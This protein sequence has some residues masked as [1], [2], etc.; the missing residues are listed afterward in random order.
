[1]T[2]VIGNT[3]HIKGK[4]LSGTPE[5]GQ[6]W[7]FDGSGYVP[8][9]PAP[10]PSGVTTAA[11]TFLNVDQTFLRADHPSDSLNLSGVSGIKLS[12][13]SGS[14][15]GTDSIRLEVSGLT[16]GQIPAWANISGMAHHASGV[17][18]D[19]A[20]L[21]GFVMASGSGL[22]VT[23]PTPVSGRVLKASGTNPLT[24]LYWGVDQ[25]GLPGSGSGNAYAYISVQGITTLDANV[26]DDTLNLSGRS[27][28]SLTG[29]SGLGQ[30]EDILFIEVSGLSSGQ[31]PAWAEISG[32]AGQASG[33]GAYASGK[34]HSTDGLSGLVLASGNGLTVFQQTPASGQ[35]LKWSGA[36]ILNHAYFSDDKAQTVEQLENGLIM[37]AWDVYSDDQQFADIA[38]D[39]FGNESGIDQSASTYTYNSSGGWC[40]PILAE[41][42]QTEAIDFATIS[43]LE[44]RDLKGTI[45]YWQRTSAYKGYFS[46]DQA[47]TNPIS[48]TAAGTESEVLEGCLV[49]YSGGSAT[50]VNILNDGDE[51]NEVELSV[52]LADAT[53]VT[54]IHGV[55]LSG[56]DVQPNSAVGELVILTYQQ[57]ADTDDATNIAGYSLRAVVSS[58]QISNSGGLVSV[59]IRANSTT[60][61]VIANCS[62]VERS[63]GTGDGATTPTRITFGDGN[64]GATI[65]A[66]TYVDSDYVQF[67]IDET[68]SYL[69][70]YDV[71]DGGPYKTAFKNNAEYVYMKAATDSWNVQNITEAEWTQYQHAH[72][73][74][75]RVKNKATV[76]GRYAAV[77]TDLS[78]ID[79]ANW[80]DVNNV[81][82]TQTLT[83][84]SS[85][86]HAISFDERSTWNVFQS[87]VWRDIVR[88]NAG[89]WQYK[90]AADTWQNATTNS[91][92]KALEQALEVSA[93][94]W[95]KT[96]IEAMSGSDWNASG[97]WSTSAATIDWAVG[98]KASGHDL[99]SMDKVTFNHDTEHHDMILT[100][101]D[102]EAS[103]LDPDDAFVL[104]H[105]EPQEMITLDTDVQAWV[106]IDDGSHYEQLSGLEYFWSGTGSHRFARADK[107]GLIARN[108]QTMRLK[109]TT[110]NQK[111]VRLHAV[112]LGVKYSP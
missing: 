24:D 94:Q 9:N 90:D 45:A 20:G 82:V 13:T 11:Y 80:G 26:T 68:K 78:Q 102:W 53:E 73:E 83:G 16:S 33:M 3:T 75:L 99:P 2:H 112:A 6:A 104:L 27:G 70:I 88:D 96:Q 48:I 55:V 92:L 29:V 65:P 64:N 50:I 17:V 19:V 5:P 72:I 105:L 51:D 52:D 84:G 38:V 91:R 76:S 69:V 71:A 93:N 54:G 12:T 97:G 46:S 95:S 36:D 47:G 57:I 79:C 101:T 44:R 87:G 63:A 108:D 107:S 30:G 4:P 42:N 89:T 34:L 109:V 31:I 110:H 25:T 1:M 21:S 8:G 39:T 59:R 100:T 98:L 56:T 40:G 32:M 62:I 23:V 77:S 85:A 61:L 60:Q 35:I 7:V 49:S 37:I 41:T 103:A 86:Y 43:D 106:S 111:N 18:D 10:D 22:A 67:P 58:T 14:G 81:T 15:S 74:A 28:I 66:W